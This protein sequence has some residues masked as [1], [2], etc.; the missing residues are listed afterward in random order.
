MKRGRRRRREMRR[1]RRR[2]RGGQENEK[3]EEEK[4]EEGEEGTASAGSL[5]HEPVQGWQQPGGKTRSRNGGGTWRG[6][7]LT[8]KGSEK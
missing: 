7:E 6:G 5:P 1:R 3:R 8:R 4:E 2:R